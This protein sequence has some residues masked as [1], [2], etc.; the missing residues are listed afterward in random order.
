V[1][2]SLTICWLKAIPKGI[3]SV[4]GSVAY[5]NSNDVNK[6]SLIAI[7]AL[8]E[9]KIDQR[10]VG[11]PFQELQLFIDN[12]SDWLFG[13]LNYDLKNHIEQLTSENSDS[14]DFPLLRF[15]CPE[16]L[17]IVKGDELEIHFHEEHTS[18]QRIEQLILMLNEPAAEPAQLNI[19]FEPAISKSEYLH[20]VIGIQQE[21]QLGNVYELNYCLAF[22][23]KIKNLD[24]QNLYSKLN[25]LSEAP[26]SV[27]YEDDSHVLMGASPERYLKK[28]GNKLISQ[29]IKGTRSRLTGHE[30]E[31][32]KQELQNDPKEIAEN[33]MITDLVRNDLSKIAVLNSVKVDE[34]LGLYTFKTVHQLISTVS[35]QVKTGINFS[36]IIK[37]TFPMGSMTGA[38]KV[39]AMELIEKFEHRRR[40][41]YSGA[42]GYISP[43]GDFDFNV[44]IRSILYNKQKGE[45]GFQV[46]S[47]ITAKSNP[48]AE[49]EECMVKAKALLRA[50][51]S[52]EY[53]T[54]V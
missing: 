5:L 8:R 50:T 32:Q 10:F 24:C 47:A 27:Y 43:T 6:T 51:Q 54:G 25:E 15:F 46:G 13:H 4:F 53:A 19:N 22:E 3:T 44:V 20:D 45:L 23:S 49:Y 28:T 41:L 11:N 29:P 26:F 33:V 30:D 14:L 18:Q 39:K 40:G 12:N 36:E 1:R 52:K 38:P 48:E 35:A 17:A 42:F 34:L 37:A 21:I 16:I 9:L 2:K 7:G 31:I